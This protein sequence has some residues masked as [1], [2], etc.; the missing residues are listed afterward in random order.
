MAR[1]PVVHR[2]KHHHWV[3]VSHKRGVARMCVN[4]GKLRYYGKHKTLGIP[5]VDGSIMVY[6]PRNVALPHGVEPHK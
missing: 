5:E 1:E 4:C 6:L 2:F 3:I